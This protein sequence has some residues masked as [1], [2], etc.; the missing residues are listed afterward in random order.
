MKVAIISF[1]EA[2]TCKTLRG[3]STT[4]RYLRDQLFR[5]GV[6]ADIVIYGKSKLNYPEGFS[7]ARHCTNLSELSELKNTYDFVIYFTPGR[8]WEKYDEKDP[9]RYIDVLE[10]VGLPFSFIYHSEEYRV[11]QPYRMNFLNHPDCKFLI[12][13]ADFSEL[14]PE[15]LAI[16]PNYCVVMTAPVLNS[17][18]YIK[19]SEKSNSI[20]MTSVWTNFKRNLEYFQLTSKFNDLGIKPYSAGAPNSNFYM[21]DICDLVISK[22]DLITSDTEMSDPT[23]VSKYR[24]YAAMMSRIKQELPYP[25]KR[26]EENKI[27]LVLGANI[28]DKQGRSWFDYGSYF[29]EDMHRILEDKKFHWNMSCYKIKSKAYIPR[30]ETVTIEAFNEGCLPV[31][32]EETTPDWIEGAFRFSKEDYADHID[33]LSMLSEEERCKRLGEF[34]YSLK[35]NWFDGMYERLKEMMEV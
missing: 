2:L 4:T 10:S 33:E 6:S 27:P 14:Y 26:G 5:V 7:I 15:D 24:D 9:N 12:F 30:L 16:V 34:Y 8:S 35:A 25:Y 32:C 23:T 28:F 1:E 11:H 13:V 20:I 3:V 22:I 19:S 21:N 18:E 17:L 29:P 31:L